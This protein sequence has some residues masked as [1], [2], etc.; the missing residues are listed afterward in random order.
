MDGPIAL[1]ALVVITMLTIGLAVLHISSER[2]RQ[3]RKLELIRRKLE[4]LEQ[5]RGTGEATPHED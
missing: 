4:R 1:A 3:R 2:E 5:A